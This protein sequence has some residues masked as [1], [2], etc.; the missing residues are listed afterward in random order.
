[1]PTHGHGTTS[2]GQTNS[3]NKAKNTLKQ[4]ICRCCFYFTHIFEFS[5]FEVL[6]SR[7]FWAFFQNLQICMRW[8]LEGLLY[9]CLSAKKF[10]GIANKRRL[11]EL[12]GRQ[13]RVGP[14][15]GGGVLN[16]V[17]YGEAPPRGPTP[18]I[19]SY[20]FIY[21]FGRKDTPFI[22]PFYCKKVPLSHTYFR[23]FCSSFHVVLHK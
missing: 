1:M 16:K 3:T 2:H 5:R 6:I 21:H 17:L 20:P 19:P 12:E 10:A 8:G 15:P 14:S 13:G 7:F 23:K 22:I 9:E 18:S 11:E 4:I